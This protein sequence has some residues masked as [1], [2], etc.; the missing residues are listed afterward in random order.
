MSPSLTLPLVCRYTGTLSSPIIKCTGTLPALIRGILEPPSASAS[1]PRAFSACSAL[2]LIRPHWLGAPRHWTCWSLCHFP[3]WSFIMARSC[4]A[5]LCDW[6]LSYNS[7]RIEAMKTPKLGI[8]NRIVQAIVLGYS[9][10]TL[11]E[12]RAYMQTETPLG[13]QDVYGEVEVA[14]CVLPLCCRAIVAHRL[15]PSP[16]V[17]S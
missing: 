13:A 9:I 6:F 11:F 2:H 7:V 14:P 15:A 3:T 4:G 5:A 8:V 12:R 10:Y 17:L 16:R 1:Y